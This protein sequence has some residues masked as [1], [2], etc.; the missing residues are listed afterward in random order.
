MVS[1]GYLELIV[2]PMFSGKTTYIMDVYDACYKKGEKVLVI[3]YEKDMRYHSTL[4]S[5]HDKRTCPCIFVDKVSD[6]LETSAIQ[7]SDIILINEGQ[8]FSDIYETV[9]YIVETLKKKVFICGLDGDFKR[10]KFGRLLD[11][12]PLC[13]NIVKLKSRCDICS[14]PALFSYRKVD[15]IQQVLIGSDIYVPLCRDCYLKC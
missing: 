6:A 2:G 15:N 3:N 8:F 12:V 11:L 4:L 5:T 9:L 7:L 1:T 14:E 13:D 10:Q